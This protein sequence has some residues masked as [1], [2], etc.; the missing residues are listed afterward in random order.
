MFQQSRWSRAIDLNTSHIILFKSPRD[1]Q[2]LDHLGRQLNNTKFLRNC[3]QLA[4]KDTYGH[5]LIDLDPR[6][7][8]CLRYC[9]NITPPGPTIFY[10]SKNQAEVTP[11]TMNAK[12]LSILQQMVQLN[13]SQLRSFIRKTTNPRVISVI[14]ECLLNV[15]NGN[16]SVNNPNIENFEVVYKLLFSPKTKLE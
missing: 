16:V 10:L 2:Q 5:L 8:D 12:K 3:Y 7:S 13:P 1:I 9:S 6:T 15:V 14:C 11:L 4:T